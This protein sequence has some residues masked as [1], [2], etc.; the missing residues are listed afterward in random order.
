MIILPAI[1]IKD[2][3]CVR[4]YKGDFNTAEQVA[5]SYLDTADSFA[6]DGATWLHMVDLD[7]ARDAAPKN[8]AIFCEV[9]ALGKLKVELGG[10]IRSMQTVAYYLEHGVSRVILGSAALRDPAFVAEAV[11]AYG[12][13][14][15]VGID[16]R[17]GKVA[18]EG[19]L[20]T[21]DVDYLELARAMEAI[22]VRTI[23]FTDIS[24]DGT[25]TGPNFAQL[26]AMNTAV[27][28]DVIASGGIHTLAD[29]EKLRAMG[30]YGAICGK[31][32][33]SGAFS[34][35]DALQVAE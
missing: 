18:A 26:K 7:G 22:G 30:L 29:L 21:S 28:C 4:L 34:L 13:Q 31:S 11:R 17:H 24:C 16:A 12:E 19:W 1:D 2:G 20:D 3:R 25:L 23:I 5:E 6:R 14:I 8:S 32:L 35:K 27:S 33:Y 15:A 9:A 10:G